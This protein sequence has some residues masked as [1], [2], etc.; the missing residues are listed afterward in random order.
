[1]TEGD[2]DLLLPAEELNIRLEELLPL[3]NEDWLE[4]RL[5]LGGVL[6]LLVS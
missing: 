2:D 6:D 4:H 5:L 3:D 1:M